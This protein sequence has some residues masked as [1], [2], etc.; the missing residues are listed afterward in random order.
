MK[1]FFL[2]ALAL[3]GVEAGS[4]GEPSY[5]IGLCGRNDSSLC[6]YQVKETPAPLHI[7]FV[8]ETREQHSFCFLAER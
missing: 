5:G 3:L 8:A 1:N 7:A 2:K 6:L 4:E